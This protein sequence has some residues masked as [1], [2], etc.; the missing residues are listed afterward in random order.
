MNS[1]VVEAVVQTLRVPAFWTRLRT[2]VGKASVAVL[3][4]GVMTGSNFVV[5]V[6]LARWL[7]P[8]Q[9]GAYAIAYAVFLLLSLIF[10]ALILEPMSIFGPSTYRER[11]RSYFAVL[12]RISLVLSIF[13][14]LTLEVCAWIERKF[15][16]NLVLSLAL[17]GIAMATPCI[18][19]LWLARNAFYV[20][21]SPLGSAVGGLLYSVLLL[22]GVFLLRHQGH[23]SPLA[24]FSLMAIAGIVTAILQFIR[25]KPRFVGLPDVALKRV[26]REHWEYGRWILASSFVVWIPSNFY[27][28]LFSGHSM[29]SA[30]A[31]LRA[32]LNLTL[33]VGQTASALSLLAQ[34]YVARR[35]GDL[36][37]SAVVPLVHKV[38]VL[39]AAGAALYWI[40]VIIFKTQALHALYGNKYG[41]LGSLVPW[42][43]LSSILAVAAHGPGI[44]LRAIRSPASVFTAFCASS[45]ISLAVGIPATL[46]FGT[47]GSV[48]TLLLANAVAIMLVARSFYQ[49]VRALREVKI[50]RM[51]DRL[52]PVIDTESTI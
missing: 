29:I 52:L 27:Y 26:C 24:V 30:A 50:N 4:Q 34:P 37:S 38:T 40:I 42:L 9:Y 43:G 51:V 36:G 6:L 12:L 8:A 22:T 25:L 49:R 45:A 20:K 39:Y 41:A 47:R 11:L 7:A 23:V 18:M 16:D 44:G 46:A 28:L 48:A 32:L 17:T 31:E 15:L 13:L 10:Q 2:W 5:G 3:D 21:L 19:L 33:P 1:S 35:Q 14:V